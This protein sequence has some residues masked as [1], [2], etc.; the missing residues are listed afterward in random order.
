[1]GGFFYFNPNSWAFW[2]HFFLRGGSIWSVSFIF[3]EELNQYQSN[4]IQLLKNLFDVGY[5]LT[6]F[7]YLQQ[8]NFKKSKIFL[9]AV[10]TDEENLSMK[11][12]E[13]MCLVIIWKVIK[14]QG[15][16]PSLE[17][18]VMEK[19]QGVVKLTPLQLFMG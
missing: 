5:M 17:S 1:M 2:R 10:Y 13:T 18:T 7:D 15:L 6:S 19:P 4:F 16:N 9:K 3:Q 8:G 11:F 14:N 12:S